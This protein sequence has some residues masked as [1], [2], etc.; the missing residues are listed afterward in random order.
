MAKYLAQIIVLG[1][2]VV[3]RAFTRALKQEY[4][5]S[6]AAAGRR[7]TTQGEQYKSAANDSK[8]G[9]SLD[10]AL[11]ILNVDKKLNKE[12]VEKNYQH[13]FTINEK[14]KGGSFYLQSK[15]CFNRPL[16]AHTRHLSTKNGVSLD[17]FREAINEEN[18]AKCIQ[19][20]NSLPVFA[21]KNTAMTGVSMSAVLVPFCYNANNEPSVIV[22][23]R[24][25]KLLSHKWMICFPGG[26]QS[27]EDNDDAAKTA[28]RETV[29]EL[30]IDASAIK[31]IGCLNPV[32]TRQRDG[33]ITPVLAVVDREYFSKKDALSLNEQ[34]VERIFF[35]PLHKL[36]EEKYW[37]YTQW[38]N[39]YATPVYKDDV[40]ND[41]DAPRI[42]GLTSFMLYAIL[43]GLLPRAFTVQLPLKIAKKAY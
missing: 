27:E 32:P 7:A 24:S 42:W 1:A 28:V 26:K 3:G 29:E 4:A 39:G 38:L 15:T 12:E 8:L 17:Y 31:V 33:F 18:I 22:T 40:F 13:L 25:A 6:Q 10:E 21:R 30:G 11:Q 37:R 16:L 35:V 20:L 43:M 34:E 14:A 9:I 2:Q 23:L 19:K 36:C 41:G 5:A